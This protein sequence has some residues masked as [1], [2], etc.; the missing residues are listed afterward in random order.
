MDYFK[1]AYQF[2]IKQLNEKNYKRLI[3]SLMV[4]LLISIYYSI[5]KVSTIE[6]K[7]DVLSRNDSAIEQRNINHLNNVY[8]GFLTLWNDY[9]S[10]TKNDLT[11]IIDHTA[12]SQSD[13]DLL[14]KLI[15]KSQT[16]IIQE[17]HKKQFENKFIDTF[18]RKFSIRKIGYYQPLPFNTDSLKFISLIP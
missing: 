18:S 13:A 14:K 1:S 2:V 12:N 16:D 17:I 3:L 11:T 5:N 10:T 8:A 15:E 6:S 9:T 4:F 7:L